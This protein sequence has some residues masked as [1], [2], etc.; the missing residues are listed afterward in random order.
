MRDR[1]WLAGTAGCATLVGLE[2][3]LIS[4]PCERHS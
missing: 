4:V 3:L 1:A 2:S